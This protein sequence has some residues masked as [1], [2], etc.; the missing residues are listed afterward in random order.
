MVST[1]ESSD[2]NFA[3]VGG[4]AHAAGEEGV[5]GEEVGAS[6]AGFGERER[7][8]AGGVAGEVDHVEG[9]VADGDRVTVFEET[10]GP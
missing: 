7:D 3:G 6:A 2:A 4:L 10:V 8:G 5:A 9:D 1:S